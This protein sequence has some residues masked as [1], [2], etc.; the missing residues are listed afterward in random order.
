MDKKAEAEKIVEDLKQRG[1][2]DAVYRA[3]WF[4]HVLEDVE[5]YMT[6]EKGYD[7]PPLS[8]DAK[9]VA[10]IVASRYVYNGDYDH[11]ISY[12]DNIDALVEEERERDL[13][14]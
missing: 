7:G 13:T 4:E 12:W 5:S 6:S 3:L 9:G 14:I 11:A 1:L 8:E 2:D 10:Q